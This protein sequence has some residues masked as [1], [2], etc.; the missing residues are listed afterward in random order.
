MTE[1]FGGNEPQKPEVAIKEAEEM[2]G[3]KEQE[4]DP[5]KNPKAIS[6]IEQKDGNFKIWGQRNGK[7]VEIRAGKPEDCLGQFL[8]SA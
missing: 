2:Q 1:I 8:T 5:Y 3:T 7:M 6:I 4:F